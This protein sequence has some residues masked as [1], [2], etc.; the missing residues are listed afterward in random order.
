MERMKTRLKRVF[1][2]M[3]SALMLFT[4]LPLSVFAEVNYKYDDLTD[5]K[6]EIVNKLTPVKPA[7]PEAGKTAEDLIK[8]PDQPDIYTLR[9]DYKVQRGEKYQV[10]YQPYI[11]S[12]GAGATQAEKDKVKKTMPMPDIAGY[13]KPQKDFTID[14]D[15]VKGASD[16]KN[17]KGDATNGFRYSANEVFNYDALSNKIQ[18]KHVFQ[19]LDDFNKYTNPDGS[20]GE[21]GA[22]ITTQ[23]GNTGSTVQA[24]PLSETDPRR[25]GFIPEADYINMQ[26]PENA[27]DFILE[28]R[29]NR[30]HYDVVYDTQGGS[31]LPTRTLYYE[32]EIPKI[33]D[34]S[35]PTKVGGVFQGWKPSVELT[36]KNGK[37]YK[38]NEII[39]DGNG[40]AIEKLD[41][42]LIMP[43]SNVTFTAVW[44]DKEKADY[45]V[46]FWAERADHADG[47]SLS[48]KYDYIGTRVYKDQATGSRPD[49]DT[50]PVD[51]IV[52]P[53]LDKA[54]LQK[55]WNGTKFN[56]DKYL[57]LNK[58]YVYNK[59]LTHDQN[60][61]PKNVNRV[62]KVEATGE[63]VYNIYYDRQVYDLYFTKSNVS[64]SAFYPEITKD[65]KEVGKEGNPYHFKARFNQNLVGLWPDD[66]KEVKGFTE[67]NYSLGWL[68]NLK[69]PKHFYRDTPPYRLSANLFIDFPELINQGGYVSEIDLGNGKT[70]PASITD[71]SFGIDQGPGTVPHHIDF[72]LDDFDGE[73]VI[74]YD[75]YTIKSDTGKSDYNG[76]LPPDLQGFTPKTTGGRG[77]EFKD[78]YDLE[79]FNDDREEITPFPE[80]YSKELDENGDPKQKGKLYFMSNFPGDDREFDENGYLKFEYSRNKYPLRFNY[81]PSIIRDDSYFNDKN[82]LDTFYEFPLKALS[83]EADTEKSY[84]TGNP[85]NI[86]DDPEKLQALGLSDLVFKDKNDK[87]KLKVKRPDNL[88]D[89]L[90]FKGWALDPAGT[91]LVSDKKSEKMPSHAVNLYAKWG[92]PDYQWKVTFDPNGGSLRNIK[93]E[94]LTKERKTVQVGDIGQEEI[95]TFAKKE[96]NDGDK[97]VFTV[98]QR[99]KLVAPKF[100][101]KR[102]GYDFMGWEVIRYKKDSTTGDYTTEQDTSYRE[103]Y[104]VPELYSFGNDVVSP[105]YL[106]AIWVPN[107]RVDVDVIHHFLSLDLSKETKTIP[108]TLHNKR[109]GYLVATSAD[110]QNEEYILATNDELKEKLPADLKTLYNKY[111]DRVKANNTFFQTFKVEP[112]KIDDGNGKLIPNP[113]FKDNVFH[114]FYRPFRTRDYK[115]N[116]IDERGKGEV[117]K[118][119]KG[120]N[121]TDT[122]SLKDDAL[123]KANESNKK[124]FEDNREAFEKLIK[125]YQI[126]DPEAVSNGNRHYDARNYRQIPGWVIAKNEKPQQQLFFDVNEKTNEFLGINGTGADQVF[127]YYK[128]VRVIEVPNKDDPVPDGYVRVTFKADKG[129]AFT[130]KDGNSKTELYYDV[131]KGL[132]SDLLPEPKELEEG[133][134]KEEGKYYITPETGKKF[135]KWDEKPLL[136]K[137]T[138]VDNDT[139]DFYVF[140]AKFEWSGLSASGL[141][142][143]EAFKDPNGKWTND[144]APTI[145]DLKKQL[146]WMEKGK[147]EKLPAGAVIKL[148]DEAGTELTKDEQVYNLVNE[149]GKADKDELVRTVN[150]KAKV[151][152]KDGKEPQELTIPI[153]VYKNVYEALN[154]AGDKPLF[155]KEAEAKEAKDGGLKDILKDNTENRYIKV[156]IKPNKD[157]TNKDDKVYYVNPNAWVEIPND[158]N[159]TTS[160]INWTADQDAQNENK[161]ANGKFDFTKRHKFTKDTVISPRL[162][163]TSE[164]VVHE[165]YKDS[166]NKWVNDFIDKELTDANLKKAIQ[167]KNDEAK[168]LGVGDVT[169]VDDAGEPY[170]NAEALKTALYEKLQEKDDDGKASRIEN[171]KVKVTFANGEVQT[172]TVPVKVIKNIYQAKTKTGK[173][174]Y[175]PDNYVK[176]TL[177]P[178]TKA[179]DP[180]KYFYYV[181]PDAKVL[182]P[183]KDPEGVKEDFTGW[184]MKADGAT[185]DGTSYKLSER[186]QF[187]KDSTIIAQYGQGKAKIK[188]VDENNKEIETK[189]YIV[190]E[191]YPTEKIGKIGDNIPDPVDS[192]DAEK[193][194]APK[195]KGYIISSVSVDKKPATYT[196]PATA[197]ITYKYYKKITTEDKSQ[198]TA[199]YFKVVFDANGGKLGTDETKNVYVYYQA[200]NPSIA[201][202]KFEDVK[203]EAG[204]P[205]KQNENFVEWQDKK[206]SGTKVADEKPVV[207]QANTTETFYANY[208]KASALVK[209]LDLD[210]KTISDEFKFL[211]DAEAQGL[212]EDGKK[213][214]LDKKYP[215][216][217]AGTADEAI[218][219]NVYTKDTAPKLTGYKFNRIELNPKDGKYALSN[220]ATIKIY[221][222]KDL[223]VIA[224]KDE[225]GNPNK[226]PEGYVQ[227]KFVPTDKAKDA[228]EKIFYVNPKK[229]VTIPV[230]DPVAKATFSFKEWKIGDVTTGTTYNPKTPKK[231]T[232]A[233]TTI[234]ATYESSQNIIPYDPSVSDPMV[235]PDGYVRVSFATDDG[236]KLT[237]EKAYYVKK[238][239]GIK[240][241][242]AELAK[243]GYKAETG[244][245]FTNW[246]K[247]DSLEITDQDVLVTAKATVLKDVDTVKHP[248]Y[249]K[250]TFKAG[251][252]GVIKENGNTIDEK[253]YYVNPNKYVNLKAPTPEGNT[254]YDF[255]TW[256][257]DKSQS[258]FSLANFVNYTK[259][260]VI[261]AKFNQ[262]DAVY[263]KLDGSTKPAG[264]VEVTFAISG[265]GG[266]IADS[267]IKTYYVDPNRQISLKAP[268]TIAGVGFEFDKWRMGTNLAD[269]VINPAD[270]RQY[271]K[272]TTIY[273]SFKKLEDII[274]ATNQDGTTNLQPVDYVAVLFIGGDHANKL[275]GQILYYVNPKANPAKTIGSLTKPT[276]TP[277]TGWKHTGWDVQDYTEI[278]E[279]TFVVAQYEALDD[280]I[281][282]IKAD[283]SEKPAG[284]VKVTFKA[285]ANGTLQGG[286]K[287]YFVNP[288]KYV[289]LTPPTTVPKTSFEFSTWESD[290]KD[291][292]LANNINYT[293][294]TI[295]T[296]KFNTKGDVIAKTEPNDSQKPAGFVTVNFVIDPATGG[297]IK[298]GE[299]ITYFVRPNTD[300]TIQPPK[301]TANTGYEFDK[302]SIDT[303]EARS[304]SDPVTTVKGEF[305]KLIDIIP[306][307]NPDGTVNAKPEGYVIVNFL[308]GDHG[309]LDGRTTFY[310]NPKAKKTLKDLD[311]SGITV[312]PMPTYKFDKWDKPMSTP[313]TG[314]GNIDVKAEY[315]QLPNIIKA[316]P[317][318]TAPDG[319]VVIIFETDGRGTITG[320]KAYEDKTNPK[321]NENEIVYFVNP[322]KGI[323]LAKLADGTTPTADQLAVPSTTSNDPDKY[324]FDQWRA[325]IDTDSEIIRGRVHIA[326]F[327]PKEVKLTYDAN[328]ATG[329]VPPALTV[330][331]NT[332]VR[333]AGKGNLAKKD[334]SFKGWKIGTEIHQAGDQINLKEDT[335]AIAQWDDDKK[336]IEYNPVDNPTTRPDDTY[337]RVTFAADDGLKLTEQKAYYV[338]KDANI[339]LGDTGLV[340][341]KYDVETGYKFDKW[342]KDDSLVITTDTTVTAKSTKLG[343]VIP[344]KDINGQPNA[345]PEGYKVVVFKVK[346]GDADKGSITGVNKFYVNPTE[347]VTINP[348]TTKANTGFE[349]GAW[350]KD[351]TRPTVYADDVTT[352]EARFNE[353]KD[354]V[355]KTKTD[356]SEKPKGYVTVTFEIKGQGGN[357]AEGKPTVYFVNPE[358]EVTVTPPQTVAETGYVF[359]K[360]N[361]DTTI[362][363]KYTEDTTVKGNFKKLDDIIPG[364]KDDGT[365]NAKPDAYITVT[366]DK[367]EHGTLNGQAVYYVNPKA[368]KTIADLGKPKVTAETGYKFTGWNFADAKE[369]LSDLTVIAQYKEIDD[370]IPKT[371]N[372]ETEKPEGYITVT[373]SAEENGK[374]TG[375]AVYYVNP[376]KAHVLKDK[377]PK[378]TP[379][380]G[381]DFAD[382]DTQ[383]VKSIQYKD[384]YV[385]KALYNAKNDVIPQERTDGT[386]KPAGYLKVIFANGD[387]GNLTGKTVYYVN[388]NKEVTVPAPTVTASVGYEFSKWDK[389]LKQKFTA[390]TTITAQYTERDNIIPQEKTDGSDKPF[391]Y[392]TVTFKAD[393]K[394]SL[395]GKTVY[396]VNPEKIVDLTDTAKE[397]TK[398]PNTGYTAEGGKWKNSDSKN[399]NDTF[400]KDTEF[401]FNFAERPDVIKKIDDNTKLPNGY[402]TVKLIPTDKA[403][404]ETKADKVYFVNPLKKNVTI[405]STDPVGKEI[406]DANSNT[407]TFLFKEW[408]VTRGAITPSWEKGKTIVGTFTQDTDITAKYNI[409]A[410]NITKG[411]IP[412]DN[413]VTAIN[414]IPKAEDLIKN[415]P[416]SSTDPL[417]SGTTIKYATGGEPKVNKA[418]NVTAKVEVKYPNGKTSIV[419][420]PVTVVDNVVSQIGGEDG[421]KPLVPEAYVKVTVDTTDKAT[422]NTK[423]T[424][425]FWVKPNVEVTIPGILAPKGKEV[426]EGGVT[427][428][429]NFIKWQLQ[430]SNPAK[431]YETEIRDTFTE[432]ESTIIATYEFNKNVEPK[433]KDNPW[434]PLNS[435]PEA[436]DFIDNIYDDND[437]NNKDN[438]P[439]GTKLEFVQ[440]KEPNTGDV[441]QYSTTIKVTYPNGEVKE[442]VVPYKVTGDVVEEEPGKGKPTVPNNFVRVIVKTTEKAT[443]ESQFEKTFWV[444]SEKDVTISVIN[445]TGKYVPKDQNNPND[446][447]WKFIGWESKETPVRSW[448]DT[449]KDRFTAETTTIVAKYIEG[450]AELVDIY[451]TTESWKGV[452]NYLPKEDQLKDLVTSKVPGEVESVELLTD[453]QDFAEYAYSKLSENNIDQINR[454]E[455]INA[456]VTLKDGTVSIVEIPIVVYKNIY[457]GLTNG[458]K[459][460]YVAQAEHDLGISNP[461]RDDNVYVRV[462]LIPTA[463]A[464]NQQRKTYYVRKNASVIIPE[465]IAEGR[466]AYEFI[467]WKAEKP[468]E[469]QDNPNYGW[470]TREMAMFSAGPSTTKEDLVNNDDKVNFNGRMSFD[471]NTDIVAQYKTTSPTPTP[472]EP[473][474]PNPDYPNYPE[475]RPNYSGGST[476]YIEKPVEKVIKVPD[477][478]FVKEV[479]YMQGFEGKFRPFDGLTR[480]E[481]AQILANA[482]KEDGYKYD[483][484]YK[485][486][487]KDI[488]NAWYTEAVK[489][490]TQAN[491]FKG[492]DDGNFKPQ[493]K[494][495]RAEWIGTLKRFQELRDLSG[496]HM[497]LREG[498]WAMAEI[499]AAYQAGWLA[500]Y[501]DGLADFKADE[502]IPRQ[503]VAAVSN[504]AFER[505]LDKTYIKRNDKA[506]VNY[507][508]IN[509]KMWSYE[510]I[511]C[512]SNTFL[513]DKKLYRAHG[514]DMNNEIFNIN[515]DGFTITKDKFQ[516]IER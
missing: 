306:Y 491:V 460:Q 178:T 156:T 182:I 18:I 383:I 62:K 269:Q 73:Q 489:I 137:N 340:K 404:D 320:N 189:Y 397:I 482:L 368:N 164:L 354:V 11:A 360:W 480:A 136:N 512:A 500:I 417:P 316:G 504:K 304:Y 209:Y 319:Y 379:N 263:P 111:N 394:G 116:Y 241:G 146:V 83:P 402:V 74:D 82:Q 158:S 334:A 112:E 284:Y 395:E 30:A 147:V 258:D 465:I 193:A 126:V 222:E 197:T 317:T 475:Y 444:N 390:D 66:V 117:E 323:K 421:Q 133:K 260:T 25:K 38:A 172:L 510:D 217:K 26:V 371:K 270:Q 343:T 278:K 348:P 165:S 32:Q 367:G 118:F 412:K 12:V 56:Q 458:A 471:E 108:E 180:Q 393:A 331:Y 327:K 312:V 254:G 225:S 292:I 109:T 94:D 105:I 175:V 359:E 264:Y 135:I 149:K 100:I 40:K 13:E 226:K 396:Y 345:Q 4:S 102:K 129:G 326:M 333:L 358:K 106:K 205:T 486:S 234:T 424:K 169:I 219:K 435:N 233:L 375:Q 128:D 177:D 35:I 341:P 247:E 212:D 273:G 208:G 152:F 339:T 289:K 437:P 335:T 176:V 405:P 389:A 190:G 400:N 440:D 148:Y 330:D 324:I 199:N 332:D 99:Q 20:V 497:N 237:K 127:F 91:T 265:T 506:L 78:K 63:T 434:F 280:V 59:N 200:S 274:P 286:E 216:E 132:K 220:K 401:V 453:S 353:L 97:Q 19:K 68:P 391:G 513:H 479:R 433:E 492:Y 204:E 69:K 502:F 329:T 392:K 386:D 81:D 72:W 140:T 139:K 248:D 185:G 24:S 121:L 141:V 123:L 446:F 300:V 96:A 290:G 39:K 34:E 496:N 46:Q 508:D 432:K 242:N 232:E 243:P 167:V 387:H 150:V 151:T 257:S 206:T 211:T 468:G 23:N 443:D 299:T 17:K 427:K 7:K 498:H 272:D 425:V 321:A 41:N 22:L 250:V 119:F 275:D 416:G 454:P 229:E 77:S 5:N 361:Q 203:K 315:S 110:K 36:T 307:K 195:F 67:G 442:K 337:V 210:G 426:V 322:K 188:Y 352:I 459:P 85:K 57:Y 410:E 49:L 349:F 142:R 336:I 192:Q 450:Q 441:G 21:E 173:P 282:K 60:K 47:A 430:G 262:K 291:F 37:T 168:A 448:N 6:S 239:A 115:V 145:E 88:S 364:K 365:P 228:T 43:A 155:L 75:L 377:A 76:F 213:A 419:E 159:G 376:N 363:K 235:R 469:G 52:F 134:T 51:K 186:H 318:D 293:K 79:D 346:D 2:F 431:F 268:K 65:G 221:Y 294:D 187:A 399:L 93:E 171:I 223:D 70:K 461:G 10:D 33:A 103:T 411:P 344:E 271:S 338:K 409:K 499:E 153:T 384:K 483:P 445:P 466:D 207:Y 214:A 449:I 87:N 283:D 259:D 50:V 423:F 420:V 472:D 305:T 89:Q 362:A 382:W 285:G 406:T 174:D 42:N 124:K 493:E 114:F 314:P 515:L 218:D 381:F 369:I 490:V 224:E 9:K 295:I 503:E 61:D 202:V 251:D 8:N 244:Y 413:A 487:Y 347:Y 403:T 48:D 14:Y 388:P 104:K 170:A 470:A 113:K 484:N 64:G 163:Q 478:A 456:K 438:L 29:Y 476:I 309:V 27:K 55:I 494:I 238:K 485:I 166:K 355:P 415:I 439:P 495:T 266:K 54:R 474:K 86:L 398:N 240:L 92:E 303:T 90:V 296:A 15:T 516:R 183:G 196:D 245:E 31:P 457:E 122:S 511:L 231:F 120:L 154:K 246:D 71:L 95:K 301:T 44:T 80:V 298:T 58:F 418:G 279:Y 143:T 436:K 414:D 374:L 311:I 191:D 157:F 356:D 16:G 509:D 380:T 505:V 130:D 198:D 161:A 125:E 350:D 373:F 507:K 287:T 253:I 28:Y 455:T 357:I 45:A 473:D 255:S 428:T 267:E 378:V 249:V 408:T 385:I 514:I 467:Y 107:D 313:I 236:L 501:S 463:K 194:A 342:D 144:F 372:D 98:I 1:L 351:T 310:V 451:Y 162:S 422:P 138:I 53:D 160:L 181:N 281:P 407:Y 201:N 3:L 277:D 302:W 131:I 429:N 179:K 252:N 366:F 230:A 462:T 184:T 447:T 256:K 488:G 477:N 328:G 481:A 227:V 276:V 464:K 297:K 325:K 101:P 261:T 288:N 452:N 84:K 370:V 215:T 308:K